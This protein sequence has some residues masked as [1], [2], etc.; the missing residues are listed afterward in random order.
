MKKICEWC[1]NTFETTDTAHGRRKRF[2]NRTCSAK[3]RN[4]TFGPN[5]ISEETKRKNAE[6]MS[7]MWK[8]D[9]FR[10]N[11]IERMYTNNPTFNPD[12]VA[13]IKRTKLQ[14]GYIGKNNFKYGNGKISHHEQL[15][16]DFLLSH[17]FYYN[18]AISTK[19]ARDAFPNVNFPSNYKPDFVNLQ[20]KLCIE[21]DG[22]NHKEKHQRELD[23]KKDKCLNFLGFTV[24]RFS[25]QQVEEKSV[26]KFITDW[27]ITH[28][29]KTLE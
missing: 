25:H 27:E 2:C 7:N 10:H 3:W 21:I 22:N 23:V 14:R 26:E 5:L 16:Y 13:K 4:K 8:D 17:G 1:G 6:R 29:G 18:Y 28:N 9:A 15:V 19:L 11:S 20:T 24:V 12:T